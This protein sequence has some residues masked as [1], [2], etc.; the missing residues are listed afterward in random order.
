[1]IR[2]EE[3]NRLIRYAQG[4]GLSVRFKPYVPFSK[5]AAEWSLDGKEVVVYT[6][7]SDSKLDMVLSLIHE[8]GHH[9]GFIENGRKIDPKIEEAINDEE[10]AKSRYKVLQ[11]EIEDSKHWVQIYKDTDCRFNPKRLEKQR[12]FDIWAYEVFYKTGKFPTCKAKKNKKRQL[13][14]RYGC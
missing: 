3:I 7:S 12:E 4:M 5:T 1:M 13:R 8:L 14:E 10:K 11:Y 2:D 9:K 6:S